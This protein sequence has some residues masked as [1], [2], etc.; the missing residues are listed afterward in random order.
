MTNIKC[1]NY[2]L[3]WYSIKGS[4]SGGGNVFTI[5]PLIESGYLS[6]IR[7][8]FVDKSSKASRN[9]CTLILHSWPP[10]VLS[11]CSKVEVDCV[12]NRCR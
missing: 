4:L 12:T 5:F 8:V 7:I 6:F 9:V 1:N 11:F 10:T 3:L 2:D